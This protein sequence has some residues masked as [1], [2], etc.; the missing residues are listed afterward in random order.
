[1]YPSAQT[2]IEGTYPLARPLYLFT[3]ETPKGAVLEFIEWVL[4]EEGQRLVND[5]GYVPVKNVATDKTARVQ[6]VGRP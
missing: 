1:V 6:A 4:G 3:R 2:A 5:I